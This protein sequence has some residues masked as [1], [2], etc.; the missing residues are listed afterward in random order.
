[1]TRYKMIYQFRSELAADSHHQII[2]SIFMLGILNWDMKYS[3]ND[4]VMFFL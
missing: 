2:I 4:L 3:Y 1:M